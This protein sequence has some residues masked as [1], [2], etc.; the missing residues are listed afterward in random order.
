M[1]TIQEKKKDILM[2]LII[3]FPSVLIAGT[4]GIESEGIGLSLRVLLIFYQFILV[5][6]FVDDYYGK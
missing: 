6:N 5:K 2:I 1:K 4:A 3:L